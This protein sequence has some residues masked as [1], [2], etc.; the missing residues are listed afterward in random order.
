[1]N[2][3]LAHQA[4]LT[5]LQFYGMIREVNDQLTGVDIIDA[6]KSI[7]VKP[8]MRKT[9]I[10]DQTEP[11]LQ[12]AV[13]ETA[14]H[15]LMVQIHNVADIQ[16]RF[17]VPRKKIVSVLIFKSFLFQRFIKST[18]NIL[19][20][21]DA[22]LQGGEFKDL[23]LEFLTIQLVLSFVIRRNMTV[24]LYHIDIIN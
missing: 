24:K 18:V 10:D 16:K 21:P 2:N 23:G 1:M 9:V 22:E 6:D 5:V 12:D 19:T 15:L 4:Q 3:I 20:F 7:I 11:V 14:A 13:E 17:D 8:V